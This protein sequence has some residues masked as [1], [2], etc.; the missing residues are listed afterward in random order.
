[1]NIIRSLGFVICLSG[2][3]GAQVTERVSVSSSEE[4]GNNGSGPGQISPD[5]RFVTF[6]SGATNLVGSP[7]VTSC[8][9]RFML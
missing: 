9:P 5:G 1:M 4:Q 3:A 8:A 7:H 2:F 6:G